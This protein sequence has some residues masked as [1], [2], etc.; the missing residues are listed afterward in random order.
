VVASEAL[1]CPTLLQNGF[2]GHRIEGIG[3]KHV[4]WIHNVRNTDVVVSVDDTSP[5]A[6]IRLFNEPAGRDWLRR[7]GIPEKTTTKLDL[8]GI[9]GIS[10]LLSCIKVAKWFELTEHDVLFTVFTDSME[11]YGS[12]LR[13][14]TALHGP[15]ATRQAELDF[16]LHLLN[17]KTDNMLELTHP[18]RKRIHNLK[19]YTWI[20]QQ[21][22]DVNELNDQ[23]YRFPEYW[24]DVHHQVDEID[25]LI[26]EF[27]ERTGLLKKR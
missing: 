16:H 13:E 21:G 17:Q 5:M 15:Y 10:N 8:L 3:D 25:E 9:S 14:A 4:P 18:E 12:R 6:L 22:R 24:D 2:G 23:W 27:N 19:Y 26:T 1:Q 20:E 7:R 11:L